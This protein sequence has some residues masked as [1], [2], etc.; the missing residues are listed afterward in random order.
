MYVSTRF[1]AALRLDADSEYFTGVLPQWSVSSAV[2]ETNFRG[3]TRNAAMT[4]FHFPL[5]AMTLLVRNDA[6]SG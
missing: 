2:V 5:R 1:D 3:P 4:A 6:P